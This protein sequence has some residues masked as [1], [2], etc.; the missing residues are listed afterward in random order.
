L[1]LLMTMVVVGDTFILVGWLGLGFI[2][3]SFYIHF[4]FTILVL[5]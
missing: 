3:V 2:L 1:A 4:A 5:D